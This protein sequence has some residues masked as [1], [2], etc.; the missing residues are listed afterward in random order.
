MRVLPIVLVAVF[1]MARDA[2]AIPCPDYEPLKNAYFGDLHSH[3]A[4]SLDAYEFGVRTSPASAYAFA[5]GTAVDL[6]TG[7]AGYTI[8]SSGGPLDFAAVTDHSEWLS[9]D[10]GCTVNTTSP[11]YN[12][13]FCDDVRKDVPRLNPPFDNRPCDGDA[14]RAGITGCSA[15]QTAAWQV[16]R[17]ATEAANDPCDFTTFHA[18][19]W[20]KFDGDVLHKN[21]FFRNANVPAL[22][23]DSINYPT[24]PLL[25]AGLAAECNPKN[26]CEA[27]T[28]PHN[29]NQSD[30]R[31]FTV[32]GYGPLE[33]NRMTEFQRLAEIH[34]H[35]GSSECITDSA[36][37]GAVTACDFEVLPFQIDPQDVPGYARSGLKDG[38]VRAAASRHDPLKFGFVGATDT[39]NGTPGAVA[40]SGWIGHGGR[41]DNQLAI[42]L[43]WLTSYN[44]GG[45]T[46]VWA[47]ENTR[48]ALWAALRRRETFATSGPR[49][50][51]RFYAFND[52]SDPCTDPAFPDRLVGQGAVPMGGTFRSV[53]G[54]GTPRF[55]VYAVP[56]QTALAAVD[57]VKGSVVAGAAVEKVFTIPLGGAPYCIT[58][59]D[60]AFDPAAPAFY[61][62]RVREAPT[63]RWS[64]HDC[65]ALRA[66]NPTNWQNIA[67]RCD[68]TRADTLDRMVQE[69][70][71]TSSIWHLPGAPLGVPSSILRMRDGWQ[72]GNPAKRDF[73]FRSSTLGAAPGAPRI[74]PPARFGPGDPTLNGGTLTIQ[75][76]VETGETVTVPLPATGWQVAGSVFTFTAP[77]SA[78]VR[79][80]TVTNDRVIVGG[81]G[82]AW[83]FTLDE[84]R[85]GTI[86][87]RLA[88][89]TGSAWCAVVPA[90]AAANGDT[91]P[92]DARDLFNG[93]PDAPA[94]DQCPV[95]G[96]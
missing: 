66:S 5:T 30:G 6:A 23:L 96:P 13:N 61:Y 20:T 55:V 9:S 52:T 31:A 8:T 79:T 86:A 44:P 7:P 29:M 2:A 87:V 53:P 43:T 40:E 34:Q 51:V 70:V 64:H 56:D 88:L 94:P 69:R 27:L 81:G 28:I 75:N 26:G 33:L 4:Y 21:V 93:Q 32:D 57:I 18:Y 59:T 38:L 14:D 54:G 10:Y 74:V 42:R 65:V 84:P 22:P 85:Q 72:T 39:H 91:T 90:R 92:N 16:E 60:P 37:N 77:T 17:Q 82:S 3:T 48:D 83:P 73:D 58:W 11:F 35:K 36:D 46:G 25:W 68:P 80:I 63:W 24:A 76:P 12:T 49:I 50:K 15:A 71:W 1:F 47:E 19:E 45:V 78:P 95:V 41:D 62:A 67:P 89:G